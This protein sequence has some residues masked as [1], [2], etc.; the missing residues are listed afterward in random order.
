MTG[1]GN[2]LDLSTKL[3]DLPLQSKITTGTFTIGGRTFNITDLSMTLQELMDEVNNNGA[4]FDPERDGTY[5]TL[6][7]DTVNDKMIIDGGDISTGGSPNIP[8]LG[9]PTDSSNFLQV[10]RLLNRTPDAPRL[11]DYETWSGIS[12]YSGNESKAWLRPDDVTESPSQT[13][14]RIFTAYDPIDIAGQ[15]NKLLYR[16]KESTGDV[17]FTTTR[18]R[19]STEALN[20]AWDANSVAYQDGFL[21]KLKS[22]KAGSFASDFSTTYDP[23]GSTPPASSSGAKLKVVQ[24]SSPYTYLER[25]GFWELGLNLEGANGNVNTNQAFGQAVS[26]HN[27]TNSIN[28][29]KQGDIVNAGNSFNASNG[30]FR[31][32]KDRALVAANS[33]DWNNYE[34][35]GTGWAAKSGSLWQ[36][37]LPVS[38]YSAGRMFK[39]K[40]GFSAFEHLGNASV[41]LYYIC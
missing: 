2:P 23:N 40:S 4:G 37:N 38:V 11:A 8:I 39:I 22:G 19:V 31:A 24:T 17:K 14:D 36:D 25:N 30:Y 5:I 41:S 26:S 13:D 20:H 12:I 16:R 29:Y 32:V 18:N 6:E 9:S 10:M 34:S 33:Q 1:L 21:F 3:S 15:S 28:Q 7:Y 35:L 27:P